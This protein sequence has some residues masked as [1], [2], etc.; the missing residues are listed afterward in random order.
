MKA[1]A[2][3]APLSRAYADGRAWPHALE[4]GQ[5]VAFAPVACGLPWQAG[6]FRRRLESSSFIAPNCPRRRKSRY[7]G[8]VKAVLASGLGLAC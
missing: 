8:S 6:P 7:T 3:E 4:H 2:W 5:S 1:L